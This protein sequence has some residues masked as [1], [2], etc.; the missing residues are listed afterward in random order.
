M[1]V[2]SQLLGRYTG[3][4]VV[5][6]TKHILVQMIRFTVG[7]TAVTLLRC[8]HRY[9]INFVNIDRSLR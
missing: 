5:E 1:P 8:L 2:N 9:T 4:G 7:V 3:I 6:E